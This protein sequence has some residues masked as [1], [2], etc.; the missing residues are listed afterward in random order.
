MTVRGRLQRFVRSGMYDGEERLLD[1]VHYRD[2]RGIFS[3]MD[4]R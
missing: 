4:P 2:V 1:T 3:K